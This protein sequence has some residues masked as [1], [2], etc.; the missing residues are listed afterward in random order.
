MDKQLLIDCSYYSL[1]LYLFNGYLLTAIRIFVCNIMKIYNPFVISLS[2]FFRNIVIT[3][4]ICKLFLP[5]I[6]FLA[7]ISGI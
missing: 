3:L 1:Q 6:P 7:K 2:I 5:K 4:I